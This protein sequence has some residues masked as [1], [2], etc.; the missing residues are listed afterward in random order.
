MPCRATQDGWVIVESS[1]KMSSPGGGNSKSPQYGVE[2]LTCSK[3][4]KENKAVHCHLAYLTP[5]RLPEKS[6]GQRSLVG[7][8]PWGHKESDM[9]ERLFLSF[10]SS[11]LTYMQ[12]TSCKMLNWMNHKLESRFPGQISN[13]LNYA[14]DT[15]RM[16]ES[17]EELKS[18]LMR[19]K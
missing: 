16:E 11:C 1:N 17:E 8:S 10:L 15:T 4:G 13:S 3:L 14:D 5:V 18:L 6:H 19:L 7:Y 12:S 2:Q 9:T